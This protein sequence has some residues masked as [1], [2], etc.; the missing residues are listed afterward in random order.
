MSQTKGV[1]QKLHSIC[2]ASNFHFLCLLGQ[3][4]NLSME[5]G[6]VLFG[7]KLELTLCVSASPRY[8]NWNGFPIN[9]LGVESFL[10]EMNSLH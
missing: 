10:V 9:H 8:E 4:H 6:N 7:Q 2:L 3:A 1:T 5:I